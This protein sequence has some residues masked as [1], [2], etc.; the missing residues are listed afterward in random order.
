MSFNIFGPIPGSG[1]SRLER[2][3]DARTLALCPPKMRC[4]IVNE[5][6]DPVDDPG[7]FGPPF[8]PLAA[9][10]VLLGTLVVRTGAGQHYQS[11]A[12][13]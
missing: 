2:R 3:Q 1:R 5:N 8:C 6:E 9:F 11:I 7:N 13:G 10:T 4:D 12:S